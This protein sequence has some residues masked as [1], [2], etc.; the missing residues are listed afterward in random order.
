MLTDPEETGSEAA[1]R[2]TGMLAGPKVN[3]SKVSPGLT[4]ILADPEATRLATGFGAAMEAM[5]FR[6]AP[7]TMKS[8]AAMEEK[9]L[10]EKKYYFSK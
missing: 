4:G 10:L 3:R 2:L 1:P 6:S 8:G 7:E 5:E 9:K